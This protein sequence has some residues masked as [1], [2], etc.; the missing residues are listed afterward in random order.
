[1]HT[2]YNTDYMIQPPPLPTPA[3]DLKVT[4]GP[5][6]KIG[7]LPAIGPGIRLQ[8]A[9]QKAAHSKVTSD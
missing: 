7:P 1:M 3:A 8:C 5:K 6:S 4:R 9:A 2:F